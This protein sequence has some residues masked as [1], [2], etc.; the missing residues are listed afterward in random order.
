MLIVN[1]QEEV[2]GDEGT[3]ISDGAVF[4]EGDRIAAIGTCL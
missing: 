4:I 3:I 2:W 1:G